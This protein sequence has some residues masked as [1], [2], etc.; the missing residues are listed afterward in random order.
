MLR[1]E[2]YVLKLK[3]RIQKIKV[4][5]GASNGRKTLIFL[6]YILLATGFW[7]LQSLQDE[8]ET[9][10]SFPI[11][12]KDLPNNLI[13]V[14]P[15]PSQ[16]DV[17]IKDKGT[18]LLNYTFGKEA[19][20]IEIDLAKLDYKN[21]EAQITRRTLESDVQK[22]LIT[23]TIV[24]DIDPSTILVEVDTLGQKK[25]P[26]T[27]NGDIST[28]LG[29]MISGPITITPDEV[30]VYAPASTLDTIISVSTELLELKNIEKSLSR[31]ITLNE[32][33]FKCSPASV[34]VALNVEEYTEK[35]L[36]IPIECIG[37][38]SDLT[39]RTFPDQVK[40]TAQVPLS[41]FK[42]LTES[43]FKIEI[44]YKE[45]IDLKESTI[46]VKLI[47]KPEWIKNYTISPDR[48]EYILEQNSNQ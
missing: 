37:L 38:P 2:Q 6:F 32:D 28:R 17:K 12:Y 26:V 16:V 25:V 11:R 8:Y 13:V 15:L 34:V 14:K 5:P 41:K 43:D 40:I 24:Q 22:R 3:S 30:E 42:E 29:Y 35:T 47:E 48:I 44:D 18:L 46:P 1:L 39:L 27:F 21:N 20:P 33:G 19:L 45:A 7:F 9:T 4:N 10:I 23:S 31:E 36:T